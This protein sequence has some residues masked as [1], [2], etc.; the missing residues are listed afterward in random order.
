MPISESQ[1]GVFLVENLT[2]SNTFTL[3]SPTIHV[4]GGGVAVIN[5]GQTTCGSQ[6]APHESCVYSVTYTS[7]SNIQNSGIL[8]DVALQVTSGSSNIIEA[9]TTTFIANGSTNMQNIG[10]PT[11]V[12]VLYNSDPTHTIYPVLETSRKL[13]PNFD[14]WLMAFFN[15]PSTPIYTSG[16]YRMYIGGESGIAAGQYAE[17]AVPLY[18]EFKNTHSNGDKY[19]DLWRGTR[20]YIYDNP[21][22]VK[23]R[24]GKIDT[25]LNN[26]LFNNHVANTKICNSIVY[27]KASCQDIPSVIYEDDTNNSLPA[28][29]P[30]QLAEPTL[31][32]DGGIGNFR[33]DGTAVD[34]DVSYVNDLYLPI[35]IGKIDYSD[36]TLGW[37]G[38]ANSIQFFQ[39]S[40]A[41]TPFL[42]LTASEGLWPQYIYDQQVVSTMSSTPAA[43]HLKFPSPIQTLFVPYAQM[44]AGQIP[45]NGLNYVYNRQYADGHWMIESPSSPL[46]YRQ[47][48]INAWQT[49]INNNNESVLIVWRAFESN[50]TANCPSSPPVTLESAIA[51]MVGFSSFGSCAGGGS[52]L[53][54][55]LPDAANGGLPLID[56]YHSIMDTKGQKLNPWVG[57][58]H[59]QLGLQSVYA[60][61][62]DD[63]LG[64]VQTSGDGVVIEVGGKSAQE[65]QQMILPGTKTVIA[66]FGPPTV[67]AYHKASFCGNQVIG[68]DTSFP[69]TGGLSVI[70]P[71][72]TP[73]IYYNQ[74]SG[75]TSCTVTITGKTLQPVGAFPAGSPLTASFT[76]S[77]LTL[78]NSN[79]DRDRLTAEMINSCNDT[80]GGHAESG[81]FCKQIQASNTNPSYLF[82]LQ[83]PG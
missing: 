4:N 11:K 44:P 16:I 30:S 3:S 18:L 80:L 36:K 27:N 14:S 50:Y 56:A 48:I 81:Q 17:V 77:G 29:D 25:L 79:Q 47:N 10:I 64:N 2:N 12:V 68:T 5:S 63:I 59:D 32:S 75:S 34:Y 20:F 67:F 51:N 83:F 28:N 69:Q 53:G 65:N 62:I 58:I 82:T 22:G 61:S 37:V 57:F 24:M 73:F 1:N 13:A 60:Y 6:I 42:S 43:G 74:A 66:T 40:A 71:Y 23:L 52:S 35:S 7:P 72:L 21:V 8:V 38:S 54:I 19:F 46:D 76:V 15:T 41:A 31:G 33:W 39:E 49:E 9:S 26:N 45:S 78:S 55:P 70:N